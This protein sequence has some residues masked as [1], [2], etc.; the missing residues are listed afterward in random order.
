MLQRTLESFERA[1]K[2]IPYQPCGLSGITATKKQED[3][4]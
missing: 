3:E 4:K 2:W 1:D